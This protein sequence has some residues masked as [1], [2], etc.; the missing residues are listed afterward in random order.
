TTTEVFLTTEQIRF[1]SGSMASR[2]LGLGPVPPT[3]WFGGN[4]PPPV[5]VTCRLEDPP[6]LLVPRLCE[7]RR[8]CDYVHPAAG[9]NDRWV[10]GG[11]QGNR[12][13]AVGEATEHLAER[14]HR[15]C[16]I[17]IKATAVYRHRCE[18]EA[19]ILEHIKVCPY[20]FTPPLPL[21]AFLS[22]LCRYF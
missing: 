2:G 3:T 16:H 20:K 12:G 15:A 1:S 22:E 4:G 18:E 17:L 11:D 7:G 5:A 9:G 8:G 14:S 10:H 19:R 6:P 21:A 13:V